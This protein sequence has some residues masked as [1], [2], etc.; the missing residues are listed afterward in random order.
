MVPWEELELQ[1][2]AGEVLQLQMTPEREVEP[3]AVRKGAL[4][5]LRKSCREELREPP[6]PRKL[7]RCLPAVGCCRRCC[8]RQP[9][10]GAAGPRRCPRVP[11]SEPLQR[12]RSRWEGTL[13]PRYRTAGLAL[14]QDSSC[15]SLSDPECTCWA[16]VRS[17]RTVTA[18]HTGP[19]HRF[20]MLALLEGL[21]NCPI[22]QVGF[23]VA[24]AVADSLL[25]TGCSQAG[26]SSGLRSHNFHNCHTQLMQAVRFRTHRMVLRLPLRPMVTNYVKS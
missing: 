1:V 23:V 19:D 15:K 10:Q 6:Y 26:S 12:R 8:R 21:M 18:V 11:A 17:C 14:P 25:T 20:Q 13:Q 2:P 4:P 5:R 9:V 3:G 22:P 16:A 24:A 7:G